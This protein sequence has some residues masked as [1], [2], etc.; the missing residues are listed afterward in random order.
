MDE[1]QFNMNIRRYLK[2]VG[3]TSQR[4]IENAVRDAITSGKLTG[5]ETLAVKVSL[6]IGDVDLAVN[7]EGD[8]GLE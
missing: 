7:I 8:I 5:T 6:K 4:E 1:E 3:I 2:K